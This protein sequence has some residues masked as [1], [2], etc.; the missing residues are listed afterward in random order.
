MSLPQGLTL[1]MMQN[2]WA[3]E[4]NPLL[5]NPAN[6][7][8]LLSNVTLI[9]GDNTINHKLGRNLQGWIVIGNN[10][11]TTFYDKQATNPYPQL[12]LVLNASGAC[13]INLLVF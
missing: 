13:M 10:A 8:S 7:T 3:G 2:K 11:A 6:N 12:T 5:A 1:D 4:I 9:S